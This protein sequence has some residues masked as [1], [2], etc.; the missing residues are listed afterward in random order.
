MNI[1]FKSLHD[2]INYKT[3][4]PSC[5]DDLKINKRDINSIDDN[6][7]IL[8]LLDEDLL[9]LNYHNDNIFIDLKLPN[10]IGVNYKYNGISYHRLEFNCDCCLFDFTLKIKVDFT[11]LKI[12]SISVN[13]E[14]IS[15]EDDNQ[16]LHEISNNYSLNY[17][18]Y[19]YYTDGE[20]K[21]QDLPLIN[22]DLNNPRSTVDKI[23]KMLVFV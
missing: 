13:S 18:K 10:K 5:F 4:C 15:F 6:Q 17:T 8:N 16:D 9:I 22:L 2:A 3:T 21:V 1:D 20:Q 11:N 7:L 19:T 12:L 23:K 14:T